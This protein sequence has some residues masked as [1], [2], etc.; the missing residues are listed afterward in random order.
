VP[1]PDAAITSLAPGARTDAAPGRAGVRMVLGGDACFTPASGPPLTLGR[2][3]VIRTRDVRRGEW[4][5]GEA[6]VLWVDVTGSGRDRCPRPCPS[7]KRVA[8]R[9]LPRVHRWAMTEAVLAQAARAGSFPCIARFGRPGADL[10]PA[11]RAEV[12]R[13]EPGRRT[14]TRSSQSAVAIVLAG[15]GASVVG[16]RRIGWAAGDVL[17]IPPGAVIGHRADETADLFVVE[18]LV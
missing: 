17:A 4:H 5:A 7:P 6:G 2:G 11:L 3:D 15:T 14:S 12:H 1:S 16:R 18:A 8:C 13:L 10:T 9:P